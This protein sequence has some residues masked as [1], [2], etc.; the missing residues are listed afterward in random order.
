MIRQSIF[1]LSV[2]IAVAATA[3][4]GPL[5]SEKLTLDSLT[6]KVNDFIE[7]VTLQPGSS[8][9]APAL[10]DFTLK[11]YPLPGFRASML[12]GEPVSFS[13]SRLAGRRIVFNIPKGPEVFRRSI[14]GATSV[15]ITPE[16]LNIMP[17]QNLAWYVYGV[18][19]SFTV[20]LVDIVSSSQIQQGLQQIEQEEGAGNSGKIKKAAYLQLVSDTFPDSIDLY[21]KSHEILQSVSKGADPRLDKLARQLDQRVEQQFDRQFTQS[22]GSCH[23]PRP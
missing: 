16:E 9:A 8:G 15:E 19:G 2:L 3:F 5:A 4:A 20:S 12:P 22:C 23:G 13:W 18:H 10:V 11:K 14:T 1:I 17:S 7:T 21:W 6:Q